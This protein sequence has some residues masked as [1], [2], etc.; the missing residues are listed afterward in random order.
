MVAD[1]QVA[2]CCD[3]QETPFNL[4]ASESQPLQQAMVD[5]VRTRDAELTKI[6][7]RL[8][9]L[10]LPDHHDIRRQDLDPRYLQTCCASL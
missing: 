6:T 9:T 7:D 4:V 8:P 1:P 3:V 5:L 10:M 2:V